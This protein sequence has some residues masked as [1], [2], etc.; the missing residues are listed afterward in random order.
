M[1]EIDR[2]LGRITHRLEGASALMHGCAGRKKKS[3]KNFLTRP[4]SLEM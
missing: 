3:S 1:D 2:R 4:T